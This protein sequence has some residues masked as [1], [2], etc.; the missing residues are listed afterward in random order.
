MRR[1]LVAATIVAATAAVF[2]VRAEP[3]LASDTA[4]RILATDETR[5]ARTGAWRV[6]RFRYAVNSHLSTNEVQAALEFNFSGTGLAV[7]FGGHNTPP[8]GSPNL[9]VVDIS[10]DGE[11]K[12]LLLPRSLPREFVVATGLEPGEH[13]VRVVHR[14]RDDA[15]GV[16]IESFS[17][18]TGERGELRFQVNGAENAHLVDCRAI[19]RRDD[20]VIRNE[21]VRNWLTGQC[22]LA[23]LP[24]GDGYVLELRAVGWRT[25]VTEPFAIAAGRPKS[26]APIFL[27]RDPN[28]VTSRFRFP[29][30]NQQAIRKP[31]E[32]FRA[33]F[34]GFEAKI[35]KVTL[36]RRVGPAVITREVE[37]AEDTEAA[38]YYDR[39]VAVTLPGDMPPGVY[40]LTVQVNGGRRTGFCR[41]PRS[42]HV[43]S[44][45]PVNPVFVTF[46]HLD[47]SGQYQAEYLQRLVGM[48]NLIAP[49][50][51]LCSNACNPAYVSGAYA[52]LDAPY[53]INFGNHQ[54]PGHEAWYGDPVGLID[55]GPRVSV[56]NFGHPWHVDKS[57]ATALLASRNETAIRVINAFEANAP[58]E[59]LDRFQIRMI[60][61]A[62]GIG[63]KVDDFGATPTKRIGKVNAASF[64][65]VRFRANRVELCTYDGHEI[66][67]IPF[68]READ[69]PLTV[70]FAQPNDGT[71]TSNT[72]TI[73]NR[74]KQTFPR[75]RVT[76]IAPVGEY[77]ATGGKIESITRSDGGRLA[78]IQV[79]A[80]IPAEN[81]VP[82]SINR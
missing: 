20:D 79:R 69:P 61:D 66:D 31:G 46:G 65:V 54:F 41:S 82:V 22:A 45:Y 42:V 74:F 73:D 7:R 49:D 8:Y 30:L 21:L 17:A 40:D 6:D 24:A 1:T 67:P 9:G 78:V 44:S 38:H 47:T 77:D 75:V 50:M 29:R 68:G 63:K 16:R 71:H 5:V 19:L 55:C 52:D 14:M 57:A 56:L 70:T 28:T 48:I 36:Q 80:D 18:W 64:R 3:A 33:R 51:V 53:V 2:V 23:G 37:F 62:H 81:S 12:R 43:V 76:F 39:E 26:L 58:T 32:S 34:L 72:A 59:L 4:E 35:E 60:H 13:K 25:E 11:R 10:I 27:Q 15:T